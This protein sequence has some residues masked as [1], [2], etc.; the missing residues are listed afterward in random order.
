MRSYT[1]VLPEEEDGTFDLLVKTYMPDDGGP[2]PPGGTVSNYLD[3][4]LEGEEIDILGPNGE[5]MYKGRGEFEIDGQTYHFA[6]INL[7]AGGSGLTPHWQLI[8]AILTDW[9]ATNATKH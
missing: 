1:P 4:M 5:I 9:A 2:F 6:K 3:V 8:H 7:V